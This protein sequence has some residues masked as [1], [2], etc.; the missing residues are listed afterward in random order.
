MKK[1]IFPILIIALLAGGILLMPSCK[2]SPVSKAPYKALIVTGQNNHEWKQSTP[3]LKQ[4]LENSGLFAVDIA[5]TPAAGGDMS[6]FKPVF[7]NYNLVVLDYTGDA[8]PEETNKNF[9][10]YVSGGGGVVVYHA[11]DNAFRGWKEYNKIIGLGGW[12]DR[13][14]TDGPYVRWD[15]GQIVRDTT[16]GPG[17]SHGQQHAFRV[18]TREPEHP[19]M[20]GL[21]EIWLHS[22]DELYAQLRGPAENLTVLATSYSDSAKGGTKKHEP[23]LMTIDYGKGRVFHTVLGHAMGDSA[24][25]AMECVGFIVTL[26]RG[27]EWAAT[28]SV[29][30]AVP[31]DFPQFNTESKWPLFRPLTFVEILANLKDYQPGDTRT[32]LQDL[33]NYIKK[34]YDGGEKSAKIEKDLIRFLGGTGTPAAKN[35]I[36]KELS[37]FGT[38]ASLP[39][40]KK[41]EKQEDTKEMAR[42]AI[43]RITSQYTN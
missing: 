23:I 26:Q 24:H 29:T 20:K 19:I 41:L 7:T 18:T 14:E 27:A 8:W 21:P 5:Q 10:S 35:F 17:G 3:I 36:C 40:L 9:E 42:F 33:S 22:Q 38:D 30:Q 25:P 32:N 2:Q 37:V 4:I 15:N 6:N 12:G 43:E 11:A 31:D 39:V 13:N 34:N 1:L 28:G 16:P